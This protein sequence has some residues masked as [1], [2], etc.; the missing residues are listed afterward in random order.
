MKGR[1]YLQV[2]I[3]LIIATLVVAV[4]RN[5]PGGANQHAT[6]TVVDPLHADDNTNPTTVTIAFTGDILMHMDLVR[7]GYN[8]S[9]SGYDFTRVFAPVAPYLRQADYTVGNLETRLAG[10]D[11]GY[12]GYP[13]F[14]TP[15][16]LAGGLKASG[17]TMLAT[18]N[19]HSMDM[20]WDG[21]VHTLDTLDA[22]GLAHIGTARSA[23][24]RVAPTIVT[25]KGIRV[26]LLNYTS[27]TNDLPA[28]KGRPYAVNLLQP[29]VILAD[30]TAARAGGADVVIAVLHFGEEY[31]RKPNN[32]Q[33]NIARQ[34]LEG[35]VD[36]IIGAHPHVVQ[37]IEKITVQRNGVSYTGV[38]AFSLGNFAST[39]RE[40]YRDAGII[41]YLTLTK[42]AQGTAVTGTRFLPVWVQQAWQHGIHLARVLPAQPD[43]DPNSD[44]PLTP[45]D[46]ARLHQV[47]AD[48][49]TQLGMP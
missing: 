10:E 35:G 9:T 29:E 17:F 6:A 27:P 39:Q 8:A 26:A 3:V 1:Y 25:I 33:R 18:A 12:S 23:E 31:E 14:N 28:P 20:E 43:T 21:V 37:P 46:E 38:V 34:L 30:T 41:L 16:E 5:M 36:A 13:R 44:L 48:T 45:S 4:A 2:I 24:E 32:Y 7:S 11:M 49:Q 22:A 47:W 40:R 19:N 42:D 15:D